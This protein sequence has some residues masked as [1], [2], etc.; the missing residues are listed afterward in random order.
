MKVASL[1]SRNVENIY[2]LPVFDLLTSFLFV[3]LLSN[4][5][6][7]TGYELTRDEEGMEK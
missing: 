3:K 2:F 5:N 6:S 4:S 1:T 7:Q